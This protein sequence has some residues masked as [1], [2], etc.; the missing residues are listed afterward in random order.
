MQCTDEIYRLELGDW[1]PDCPVLVH[2]ILKHFRPHR[3]SQ[4]FQLLDS[5]YETFPDEPKTVT[6]GRQPGDNH[7]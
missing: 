3:H 6:V 4:F 2:Q 1:V 7:R 5:S